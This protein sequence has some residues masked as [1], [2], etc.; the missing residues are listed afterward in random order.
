MTNNIE[1]AN[2]LAK[3]KLAYEFTDENVIEAFESE[4]NLYDRYSRSFGGAME[5]FAPTIGPSGLWL[6]RTFD[7]AGMSK[8]EMAEA[9]WKA[10]ESYYQEN[11]KGR[12]GDGDEQ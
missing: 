7:R 3:I 11:L 1:L 6:L 8:E 9:I 12:E 5:L 4:T 2:E 10:A